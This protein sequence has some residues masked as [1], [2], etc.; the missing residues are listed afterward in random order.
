MN[1]P[2]DYLSDFR[3]YYL[4]K[5]TGRV[6][7]AWH[8]ATGRRIQGARGR[9]SNWRNSNARER[10]RRDIAA[11]AGDQI[12]SRTPVLRDRIN[13]GTGRPHRDDRDMGRLSDQSLARQKADRAYAQYSERAGRLAPRFHP[14]MPARGP[15]VQRPPQ[16]RTRP[17]Q[18][19]RQRQ[20][21][22]SR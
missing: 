5:A 17:G 10:G 14:D 19:Q 9:F 21:R 16:Q 15:T 6:R 4:P 22:S 11:R 8:Q 20:M 3:R 12:R 7:D 1:S 13:R 18:Q 2:R